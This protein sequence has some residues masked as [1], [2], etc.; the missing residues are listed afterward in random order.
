MINLSLALLFMLGMVSLIMNT[1]L[2]G[3][4]GLVL[5]PLLILF[6]DQSA[7]GAI[8]TSFATLVVGGVVSTFVYSRQGRVDYR[9]GVMLAMLTLPGVVAGAFI[10]ASLP[11]TLFNTILGI[12]TCILAIP[13]FLKG[14]VAPKLL[15][16]NGW[17]RT[18]VDSSGTSFYYVIDRRIAIP[19][20]VLTGLCS[21]IF[22]AGGGLILTPTMVLA[23]FPIHIALAT[24]RFV[25]LALSLG[26]TI[27][28]FS[29]GQMQVDFVFWPCLGAAAG[30]FAG[31]RLARLASSRFLTNAV[32][33]MV[34][35]LG[36]VLV[37][38]SLL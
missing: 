5:V 20:A 19:S 24:M 34:L 7:N 16:K 12:V 32:A 22:G 27:T 33:L 11:K 25:A 10:T 31:A 9:A 6:F 37:V 2:G 1:S 36:F 3:G 29:L 28:R 13:M 35:V 30:A 15:R 23:G 17:T 18:M 21:G 8:A 4:G 38:Q 14:Q 26:G